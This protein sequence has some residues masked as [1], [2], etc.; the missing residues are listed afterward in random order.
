MT[1]Q[2]FEVPGTSIEIADQSIDGLVAG[3]HI[4]FAT[5]AEVCMPGI[6]TA[7]IITE[8]DE[9]ITGTITFRIHFAAEATEV[10]MHLAQTGGLYPILIWSANGDLMVQTIGRIHPA[11][12]EY[13]GANDCTI[14]IC[15]ALCFRAHDHQKPA[16]SPGA[17][18][19]GINH[20]LTGI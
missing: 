20:R 15:E 6:R 19:Q 16:R 8:L 2:K 17:A 3:S 5:A 7:P 18:R 11:L 14:H 1:C 13:D 4:E 10:L 12:P 9:D